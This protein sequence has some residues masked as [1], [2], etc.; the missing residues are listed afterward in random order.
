ML[1]TGFSDLFY[2]F[3]L[4]QQL[5]HWPQFIDRQCAVI[6]KKIETISQA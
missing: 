1:L 2:D 3:P 6:V 4:A 5:H